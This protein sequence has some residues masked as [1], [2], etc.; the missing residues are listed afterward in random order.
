MAMY[1]LFNLWVLNKKVPSIFLPLWQCSHRKQIQ[2]RSHNTFIVNLTIR[3]IHDTILVFL[4]WHDP[5]EN[6]VHELWPECCVWELLAS[7]IFPSSFPGSLLSWIQGPRTAV[8]VSWNEINYLELFT[9]FNPQGYLNT[10]ALELGVKWRVQEAQ[11]FHLLKILKK[12][13]L[14][15][16]SPC[17]ILYLALSDVL[18]KMYFA[19]SHF[20]FNSYDGQTGFICH[21]LES[22]TSLYRW[23]LTNLS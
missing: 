2:C 20:P 16:S 1:V 4:V 22:Y 15:I 23:E 21:E 19:A 7:A 8:R 5:V 13:Y 9:I 17:T 11:I 12:M 14:G 18:S 10:F 6:A 3:K